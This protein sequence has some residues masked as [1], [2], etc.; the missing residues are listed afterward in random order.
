MPAVNVNGVNISYV[1]E[2]QGEPILFLHGWV[3]AKETGLHKL[4][5]FDKITEFW[6]QTLEAMVNQ[7]SP[8]QIIVSPFIQLIWWD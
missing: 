7:K 5:I 2:G 3:L 1:D 6:L 8:M 4:S